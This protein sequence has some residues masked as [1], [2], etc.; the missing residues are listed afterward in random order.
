MPSHLVR[1]GGRWHKPPFEVKKSENMPTQCVCLVEGTVSF[2]SLLRSQQ[3]HALIPSLQSQ[4]GLSREGIYR[5]LSA[6][7]VGLRRL[8]LHHC[9]ACLSL[10]TDHD[11]SILKAS[12]YDGTKSEALGMLV[13]LLNN[14]NTIPYLSTVHRDNILRF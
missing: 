8:T 10:L 7:R 9:L 1:V 14:T 11:R 6:W 13:K 3:S 5:V 12:R 2:F 4:L